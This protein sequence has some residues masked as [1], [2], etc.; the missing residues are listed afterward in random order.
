MRGAAILCSLAL[1]AALIAAPLQA[2]AASAPP[3]RIVSS[4]LCADQ[5]LLA[6]ADPSQIAA[7]SRLARDPSLS[8][9]HERA[10]P[11]PSNTG[12]AE[13]ILRI[14][15]DLVLT[16]AFERR[17]TRAVLSAQG[18]E[19]LLVQPW[20]SFSQGE[21]QIREIAARL[22]H[23]ERGEALVDEIEAA[24]ERLDG[25]VKGAPTSLT[26]ERRGYV[27]GAKSLV[28]AMTRRAGF[29]DASASV[30]LSDE[31]FVS[32][33]RLVFAHPDYVVVSEAAPGAIDEGEAF[34]IHPAL[35]A[36]YPDRKRLVVDPRL[37]LC[38]GPSTP[39]MIDAFAAQV[40]A[41]TK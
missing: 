36:L 3:T 19:T 39:A 8:Y 33:E 6:L 10:A 37:T 4:N 24:L 13:E 20:S 31:G 21:E 29:R 14:H 34:L 27:P 9:L 22:G 17:E 2:A 40:R 11:F 23:P 30:G 26:I 12:E 16:G 32:V 41:K 15:P 25:A 5:L 7:L 28:A 38:A 18:V 1:I 35:M